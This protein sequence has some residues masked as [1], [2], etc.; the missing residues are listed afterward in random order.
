ML[1]FEYL[2]QKRGRTLKEW[3]EENQIDSLKAFEVHLSLIGAEA[4]KGVLLEVSNIIRN[5]E[6][7]TE[8]VSTPVGLEINKEQTEVNHKPPTTQRRPKKQPSVVD[9]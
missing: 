7:I 6:Q 3:L 4:S 1:N 5:K 2:M 9:T 8:T